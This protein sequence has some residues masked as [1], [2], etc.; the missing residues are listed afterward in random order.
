MG[1]LTALLVLPAVT[2]KTILLLSVGESLGGQPQ[3][4]FSMS[5]WILLMTLATVDFP[6][7]VFEGIWCAERPNS[8]KKN[9]Y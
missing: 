3:L 6:R 4:M 2:L 8:G 1:G 7:P 5:G 9:K